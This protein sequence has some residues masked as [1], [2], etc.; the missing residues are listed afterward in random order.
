MFKTKSGRCEFRDGVVH[1]EES[2]PGRVR[3]VYQESKLVTALLAGV[4]IYLCVGLVVDVFP[5][6]REGAL[7]G[8]I[9]GVVYLAGA[10]GVF[11]LKGFTGESRIPLAEIT[12]VGYHEGNVVT[13]PSLVIYYGDDGSKKRALTFM[14]VWIAESNDG[15]TRGKQAFRERGIPLEAL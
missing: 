7:L 1:V 14:P 4:G 3:R 6:L 10:W 11:F 5:F 9:L 13:A 8:L 15:F 12:S 2:L